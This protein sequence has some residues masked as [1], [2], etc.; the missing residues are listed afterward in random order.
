MFGEQGV[1]PSSIREVNKQGR[2][3]VSLPVDVNGKAV[4]PPTMIKGMISRAFETLTCSRFRMFSGHDEP[5]TYRVDPAQAN[6]LFP[7]VVY[8]DDEIQGWAIEVLNGTGTKNESALLRD[9]ARE[10]VGRVYLEEHFE[11]KPRSGKKYPDEDQVLSEFRRRTL[12]GQWT[13]AIVTKWR[14]K[15]GPVTLVTHL[16]NKRRKQ[17]ER[18]F[19]PPKGAGPGNEIEVYGFPCRTAPSGKYA[20]DLY[21]DKKYERFFFKAQRTKD[22]WITRGTALELPSDVIDKYANVVRS[23]IEMGEQEKG[24]HLLNRAASCVGPDKVGE[25][26]ENDLV[27]AVLDRKEL[28]STNGEVA[29]NVKVKA[30]LP[31]MVGRRAY[32][33]S[34][35]ELA[36]HQ[37][38]LPVSSKD[39]ASAADRV[40][41]YVVPS[42]E[43]SAVGGDV[44]SRGRISISA[45]D[46]SN[47]AI[48]RDRRELPPLL[49]PKVSSARRFLT[50]S[51]G[52]TP[53]TSSGGPL[54]RGDYFREGQY[55]GSACYPVHRNQLGKNEFPKGNQEEL[56]AKD[57]ESSNDA[58]RLAVKS[59][60]K[61]GSDFKCTLRYQNLSRDELAALLWVL[62]PE[63]L[64]PE[65][66]RDASSNKVGYLRMGLGKPYGL[67]VVE[68]R[69]VG[70]SLK[71]KSGVNLAND[72][73]SLESCDGLDGKGVSSADFLLPK[74]EFL[75]REPWV[76]A[77]RR[78]AYGYG[79]R[80]EVRYMT[81]D[82][83]KE[84]NITDSR[85][86]VPK[87]NKGISPRDLFGEQA[88]KPLSIHRP[89]R[90]GKTSNRNGGRQHR[91]GRQGGHHG[92]THH[93]GRRH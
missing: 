48:S 72:Y 22:G 28:E 6:G 61:A 17:F 54:R 67:G 66:E 31:T 85:T 45:V 49:S 75:A 77:M 12:H 70:N 26:S 78:A 2:S 53:L 63:N 19:E 15:S 81:L 13:R 23:Y 5:L 69:M 27:F 33:W 74:E 30:I 76:R 89:E 24:R 36:A 38:V 68:V 18:F 52:K 44:A 90:N 88:R 43:Q 16:W 3:C 86:G 42:P 9:S 55:L 83:N 1:E 82:E 25:L 20:R 62:T 34:P 60:I 56:G 11:I 37:G 64:V 50:D 10:G 92:N 35:T 8:Y 21:Q 32:E 41:G 40:F 65:E 58:V 91:G 59:W 14:G 79:D 87:R 4:V 47:A 29:R 93:H 57:G 80:V 71:A 51:S 39:R 7:G 84:N 46:S 73:M